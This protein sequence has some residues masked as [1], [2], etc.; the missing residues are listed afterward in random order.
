MVTVVPQFALGHTQCKK[1]QFRCKNTG[2]CIPQ[3]WVCDGEKDCVGGDDEM[4]AA[5]CSM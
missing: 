3:S 2:S 5:N 1:N 4:A